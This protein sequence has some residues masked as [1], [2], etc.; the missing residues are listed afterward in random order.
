MGEPTSNTRNSEVSKL[1]D[2]GYNMYQSKVY[3]SKE[4]VLDKV[5][6]ENGVEE[7]GNVVTLEDIITINKK[8]EKNKNIT[9]DF[10]L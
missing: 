5:K 7:Y 1:L 8:G 3:V 6:I 2:Y 4:K 9:Y 10:D